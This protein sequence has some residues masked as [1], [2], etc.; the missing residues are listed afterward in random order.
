[1]K[2]NA[3]ILA[4]SFLAASVSAICPTGAGYQDVCS[5]AEFD[6]CGDATSFITLSFSLVALSISLIYMYGKLKEDA[7]AST[8]AKDEAQNLLITVLLF[9][10]LLAFFT[11]SCS[12]S[13]AYAGSDPFRAADTYMS[14]LLEK[15]GNEVIR[16][17]TTGSIENQMTATSAL[18]LGMTPFG[19]SGVSNRAGYKA[20]SAQKE[21]VVDLYLPF[22]ASLTAQK[23][24]LQAVQWFG[25]SLL[26]PFAFVM[27]LVPPTRDFGN[28]LIALFFA[29]YIVAPAMYVM[30]AQAFTRATLQPV[31]ISN[32]NA[33]YTY[34]LDGKTG[35]E[36]VR[37]AQFYQIGSTIPQAVFIPNIV[38]IVVITCTMALSKALKAASV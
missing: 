33:F 11:A 21:L 25:A 13:A 24:L 23:Y 31:L 2:K 19:G 37:R 17:L 26:L 1:M 9:I 30:S 16:S 29:L 15:N 4:L 38:L 14:S 3:L 34:G 20:L 35:G 6:G 8:W 18:F 7:K 5:V 27:R 10:G 28:V 32:E 22:I 36:E 12:I